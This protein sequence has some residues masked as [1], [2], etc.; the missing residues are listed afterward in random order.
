[1]NATPR[2]RRALITGASSGIG[3][4]MAVALAAQGIDL[5]ITARR[6]D[7][8]TALATR[9]RSQVAVDIVTADLSVANAARYSNNTVQKHRS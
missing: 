5:V 7:A 1:M 2:S 4:A 8:L 6:G 9:L 3:E